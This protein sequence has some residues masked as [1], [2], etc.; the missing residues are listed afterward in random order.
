[1]K[2]LLILLATNFATNYFIY[3]EKSNRRNTSQRRL[4]DDQNIKN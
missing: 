3:I 2:F 4:V 1:M